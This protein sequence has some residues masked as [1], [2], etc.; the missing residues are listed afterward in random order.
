MQPLIR[1]LNL[2][3]RSEKHDE[4]KRRHARA[5][6]SKAAYE[7]LE[8]MQSNGLL[9]THVWETLEPML[10]EHAEITARAVRSVLHD[11]PGVESE[12]YNTAQREALQIQRSMLSSLLRDG[13][14]SEE[15]YSQLAAEVDQALTEPQSNWLEAT[16]AT[17]EKSVTGLMAIIIPEQDLENTVNILESIGVPI[18]RMPSAGEFLGRRNV[19]ILIGVPKNQE[20]N[21][22]Q[23]LQ[24]SLQPRVEILHPENDNVDFVEEPAEITIG[25]N[26]FYFDIERYEEL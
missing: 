5:V 13:I 10:R 6:M 2:I 19:T 4:Y 18:V 3:Q 23:T 15:I 17:D 1:K 12:D 8:V 26:F 7:R 14:I 21:I 20:K 22:V 25:A 11:D 24:Q 9:S 16:H